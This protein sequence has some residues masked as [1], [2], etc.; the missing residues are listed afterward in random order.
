MLQ[1]AAWS[2][3]FWIHGLVPKKHTHTQNRQDVCVAME[4]AEKKLAVGYLVKTCGVRGAKPNAWYRKT[5]HEL[6]CWLEDR[7]EANVSGENACPNQTYA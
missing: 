3:G 1:F 2:R 4:C 7:A 6:S 5:M